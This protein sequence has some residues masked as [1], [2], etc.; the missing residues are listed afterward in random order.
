MPQFIPFVAELSPLGPDA[1]LQDVIES[2]LVINF[3][4][5]DLYFGITEETQQSVLDVELK[6][7]DPSAIPDFPGPYYVEP[8]KVDQVFDTLDTRMAKDFTVGK[9]SCVR[10][11]NEAGGYTVTI[12][13]E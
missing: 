13:I 2:E 4:A 5:E 10:E 11:L 8:R 7:I 3:S 6:V 9:I 1:Y 12:G